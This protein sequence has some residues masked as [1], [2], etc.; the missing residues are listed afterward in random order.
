M[1]YLISDWR[2]LLDDWSKYMMYIYIKIIFTVSQIYSFI[3][4]FIDIMKNKS[5]SILQ[6]YFYIRTSCLHILYL[7]NIMKRFEI[8]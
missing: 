2:N 5:N 7:N 3:V 6:I 1:T 4:I 8:P